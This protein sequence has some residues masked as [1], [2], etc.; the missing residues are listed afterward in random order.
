MGILKVNEWKIISDILYELYY[1]D[2]IKVFEE[3]FLALIRSLIP[4]NQSSFYVVD[5]DT[6]MPIKEKSVFIDTAEDM[7]QVFYDHIVPERNYLKNLFEYSQSLV[8]VDS[9]VLDDNIR[10]KTSFYINYLEPQG[11]PYVCGII[12]IKNSVLLGM[13][14]LFRS[15]KWEDFNDKEVFILNILKNHI[16]QITP[17][18][19][20]KYK[21]NKCERILAE[22]ELD[23]YRLTQRE[24]EILPYLLGGY[25]NEEISKIFFISNSTT[26]KH[27]Y[28]VF[29][30]LGVNNRLGLIK[31]DRE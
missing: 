11:I 15:E 16:A 31:L 21:F 7:T 12:I 19:L 9:D 20:D 25:T 10:N 23:K 18:L 14:N 5:R 29:I 28:N 1:L 6:K 27:I 24:K 13:M 30:K 8:Y 3:K 17:R 22:D 2:D 4:Y 26:K